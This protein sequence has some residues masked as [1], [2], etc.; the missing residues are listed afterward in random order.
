MGETAS[1]SA[2]EVRASQKDKGETGEAAVEVQISEGMIACRKKEE[3]PTQ[4]TQWRCNLIP[5][6]ITEIDERLSLPL[7]SPSLKLPMYSCLIIL[8]LRARLHLGWNALARTAEG[9]PKDQPPL[10]IFLI[11]QNPC[12]KEKNSPA[13]GDRYPFNK[14]TCPPA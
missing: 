5:H 7:P 2:T 12:M 13:E 3:V 9:D 10:E 6:C 1:A 8:V 14:P 4:W 11:Y